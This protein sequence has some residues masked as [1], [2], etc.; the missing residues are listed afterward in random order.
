[1]QMK[2]H[3][4]GITR[5]GQRRANNEDWYLTDHDLGLFVVADGLGGLQAGEVAAKTA[6]TT[7]ARLARELRNQI[8]KFEAPGADLSTVHEFTENLVNAAGSEVYNLAQSKIEYAG[9]GCTLTLLLKFGSRAIMGHVGD[10]RL[11]QIRKGQVNRLSTDHTYVA[12][13][14]AAGAISPEEARTHQYSHVLTRTLGR[15]PRVAVDVLLFEALHGDR[16]VLCSDGLS[17]YLEGPDD[18]LRLAQGEPRAAAERLAEYADKKGGRDNITVVVVETEE[19]KHDSEQL[20]IRQTQLMNRLSCIRSLPLFHNFSHASLLRILNIAQIRTY[21]AEDTVTSAG[22]I[23]DGIYLLLSG[24]FL[25]ERTDGRTRELSSGE[26]IG[27]GSFLKPTPHSE[28]IT[29]TTKSSVLV[30]PKP[31]LLGLLQR[32]PLVG[33][34]AYRNLATF[35]AEQLD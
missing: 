29:A 32:K 3:G 28:T 30:L 35:L 15:D 13:L 10:S 31:Q 25:M 9:M 22:D 26:Y 14:V 33:L 34:L 18:L 24:S 4:G 11:Y 27:M 12:E 8:K 1:M 23:L 6:V 16:F 2:W 7:V 5:T 20:E 21:E 17:G 19:E